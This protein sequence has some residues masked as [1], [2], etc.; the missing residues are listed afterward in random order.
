MMSVAQFIA[1]LATTLF[2]GAA[3]YINL[4]EHPAR[5]SRSTGIAHAVWAPSYQRAVPVM[6][7]SAVIGFLGGFIAWL[8]GASLPWL[9]A[10]LLILAVVPITLIVIF[11]TNKLLLDPERDTE[12]VE[13]R[14]LLVKWGRLHAIRSV[15]G[16][17]AA[18]IYVWQLFLGTILS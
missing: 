2:A 5:M 6:A 12:S 11:P 4:V 8:L 14:A 3:L 7:S 13:T 1:T 16:L 9:I 15:L 10:S 17:A 18:V